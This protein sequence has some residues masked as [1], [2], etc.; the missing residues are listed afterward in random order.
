MSEPANDPLQLDPRVLR[1]R[2]ERAAPRFDEAAVLH[3][4]VSRRLVERLDYI[5]LQPTA[6]LDLGCAS[7]LNTQALRKR[8][9]RA[10]YYAMDLVAPLVAQTRRRAGR[11]RRP[12]GVC[13]GLD[14]LP[15]RNDSFD[16]VVSSLALHRVPDLAPTAR[17]LQRVLRPDGVLLFATFGPDT[18]DELRTAWQAAD[19]TPHVHGFVDMHDIGDA[20]VNARLADPVMD[21]E[22]FTLTYADVPALIRDLDALGLRNALMARQPGLTSRQRWQAMETAYQALADAEGRL[23]ATWEIA[24]GHAW[25]TD[26]QRQITGDDGAVRVPLDTLSMPHR[27]R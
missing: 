3:R 17:E 5:R 13:A 27:Q 26:A 24:Y 20:L 12:P 25:G 18:L 16:L 6:M 15:F 8:Y 21:M 2:L 23:P 19:E 4:E 9:P 14:Q 7:G 10:D 11:W 22:H 1:R